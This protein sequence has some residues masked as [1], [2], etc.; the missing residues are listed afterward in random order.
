[1]SD[2][3]PLYSDPFDLDVLRSTPLEDIGVERVTLSIAVRKPRR[4]EFIRVHPSDEM[5]VDW[6]VLERADENETYWVTPQFRT[7]LLDELHAVRLFV[8][9]DKYANVFLWPARLPAIDNRLGRR[10]HESALEIA[11]LGRKHWVRMIG[12]R[13]A[14][15]Y[16][17][18]KAR[19][20]L[21]EPAWPDTPLQEWLRLAFNGDRVI[22]KLDHPVLRELSGEL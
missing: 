17:A 3:N 4:H 14:G 1:M 9:I 15:C 20:D 21:G 8:C 22:D 2:A 11:E 7:A 16:V 10:W 18:H 12:D 19:G 13:K 6:L 5:T